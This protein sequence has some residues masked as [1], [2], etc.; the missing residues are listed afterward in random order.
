MGLTSIADRLTP[1]VPIQ[2]GFAAQP[3]ATGRKVTTLFGH[4]TSTP[5][6][7]LPYQDYLVINVGD[8]V[9]AQ[10]EID[11]LAGVGSQIGKMAAAFVKANVLGGFGNF[12][13]FRAVLLPFNVSDFGPNDEALTVA[14]FLRGDTFVSCYPASNIAMQVKLNTLCALLSGVDRDLS[15]QFGSF[16]VMGSLDSLATQVAYNYN[17]IYALI[18]T[19]PDSNTSGETITSSTIL[20]SPILSNIV[21]PSYSITGDS[22]A[23][24]KVLANLSNPA[25]ILPGATITGAG[26]AAGTVVN[27]V[28]GSTINLSQAATASGTVI[29]FTVSNTPATNGIYSGAVVSG[30]GIPAG[31]Y[32]LS[33]TGSSLTLSQ[34]ATANGTALALAVQNQ[35]SQGPEIVASVFAAEI[36]SS[37]L[38]YPPLN[39]MLAGGLVAPQKSSDWILIDPNGASEQA[40]AAGL[41]PFVVRSDRTVGFLKSI[42][43]LT[44]RGSNL[45]V[46]NTYI[47]YQD[48]VILNDFKESVFLI[49]QNPPFSNN[50][51][52][53]KASATIAGLLRGEILRE[54]YFF[55]TQGA[56][57]G[58]AVLA[59]LIQ[60]QP[61]LTTRGRIDF[62]I[63]VNVVPNLDVIAGLIEAVSTLGNFSL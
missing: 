46:N 42:V 43:T 51:G 33:V 61:S 2:F 9:S 5:G 18:A 31:A 24:S 22:T 1:S 59:P 14:K 3:I 15:G 23:A 11:G 25:G 17:S 53:S 40:L 21:A 52:G 32:V 45:P 35:V 48:L 4:M 41:S 38:P 56:F 58:V 36:M 63:P 49:T 19:M 8:P 39:G 60:V 7:G 47:S 29:T 34:N 20:N 27:S 37:V 26:I 50:P 12:P 55:E 28:S 54:A 6:T 62:Y 30:L 44:L 13:Q 10:T 16:Y 57:Q